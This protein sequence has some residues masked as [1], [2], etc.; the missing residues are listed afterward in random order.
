MWDTLPPPR[1]L[2]PAGK[3]T[4]LVLL[5]QPTPW[6][7]APCLAAWGAQPTSLAPFVAIMVVSLASRGGG[8]GGR[9]RERERERASDRVRESAR[10]EE[11]AGK[12][13]D[14][15]PEAGR[16]SPGKKIVAG[17]I[18]RIWPRR[19]SSSESA[20][21]VAKMGGRISPLPLVAVA[22]CCVVSRILA[23]LCSRLSLLLTGLLDKSRTIG[24][25][26]ITLRQG[27]LYSVEKASCA[28]R[29]GVQ[30]SS[31]RPNLL[32]ID[33][34]L[35]RERSLAW[36]MTSDSGHVTIILSEV[37]HRR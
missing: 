25:L 32:P 26:S 14:R 28:C 27:I 20:E 7:L 3:A 36:A 19:P 35:G 1:V 23:L 21:S 33:L 34:S 2:L 10:G 18:P 11:S 12:G 8:E 16:L 13:G 37:P 24:R 15:Q 29:L 4:A 30:R 5:R 9:Q 17:G 31:R 22:R 6:C